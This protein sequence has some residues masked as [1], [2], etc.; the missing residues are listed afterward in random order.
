MKIT[1]QIIVITSLC[2]IGLA[3]FVMG[4]EAPGMTIGERMTAGIYRRLAYLMWSA[5]AIVGVYHYST[6]NNV[7]ATMHNDGIYKMVNKASMCGM[8]QHATMCGM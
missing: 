1:W 6:Q 2:I 5:A 8:K 7:K 4:L 3:M